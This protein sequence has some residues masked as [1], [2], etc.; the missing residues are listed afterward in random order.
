M[1]RQQNVQSLLRACSEKER[2]SGF[3]LSAICS[4]TLLRAVS[5]VCPWNMKCYLPPL[6]ILLDRRD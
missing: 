4:Y 1:E 6:F 5:N 3:C 2:D